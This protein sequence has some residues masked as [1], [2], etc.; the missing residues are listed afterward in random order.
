MPLFKKGEHDL[1]KLSCFQY[2]NRSKEFCPLCNSDNDPNGTEIKRWHDAVEGSEG[3][4]KL[5]AQN[6]PIPSIEGDGTPISKEISNSQ[7]S[8]WGD[9]SGFEYD[10]PTYNVIGPNG[11]LERVYDISPYAIQHTPLKQLDNDWNAWIEKIQPD[12]RFARVSDTNAECVLFPNVNNPWMFTDYV[13][14]GTGKTGYIQ[15]DNEGKISYG[16][17]ESKYVMIEPPLYDQKTFQLLNYDVKVDKYKTA[18]D[19]KYK[20]EFGITDGTNGVFHQFRKLTNWDEWRGNT[21]EE[22]KKLSLLNEFPVNNAGVKL[23]K[24]NVNVQ[25]VKWG[26]HGNIPPHTLNMTAPEDYLDPTKATLKTRAVVTAHIGSPLYASNYGVIHYVGSPFYKIYIKE[27]PF[28]EHKINL[29]IDGNSESVTDYYIYDQNAGKGGVEQP[30]PETIPPRYANKD[31]I[32]CEQYSSTGGKNEGDYIHGGCGL[33]QGKNGILKCLRMDELK[34]NPFEF[35]KQS[36]LF[37]T[38]ACTTF[39]NTSHACPHYVASRQYPLIATYQ[40]TATNSRDIYFDSAKIKQ[41]NSYG[42]GGTLAALLGRG[43]QNF[44]SV[45]G[46]VLWDDDNVTVNYEIEYRP[47]YATLQQPQK[48]K[49]IRNGNSEGLQILPNTG[50][51]AIDTTENAKVFGNDDDNQYGDIST[52]SFHRFSSSVLHCATQANCNGVCGLTHQQ[53]FDPAV[54]AGGDSECRYYKQSGNSEARGLSGCPHTGVPKRAVEFSETMMA[55]KNILEPIKN[56]LLEYSIQGLFEIYTPANALYRNLWALTKKGSILQNTYYFENEGEIASGLYSIAVYLKEYSPETYGG[57]AIKHKQESSS[58]DESSSSEDN[59]SSSSEEGE[60]YEPQELADASEYTLLFCKFLAAKSNDANTVQGI[61][62]KRVPDD[63]GGISKVEEMFDYEVH[64]YFALHTFFFYEPLYDDGSKVTKN[65]E[66]HVDEDGL[67]FCKLDEDFVKPV[68]NCVMVDNEKKFIGGY[69]P[70]YKDYSQRGEEFMIEVESD[71][72]R[73]GHAMGDLT[74]DSEYSGVA[75][76]VNKEGYWI[77]ES[78]QYI[79][80]EREIGVDKPIVDEQSRKDPTGGGVTCISIKKSNSSIDNETGKKLQPKTT[81][82]AVFSNDSYAFIEYCREKIET[83]NKY[84]EPVMEQRGPRLVDPNDDEGKTYLAPFSIKDMD[85]LPTMRKALYCPVCDYYIA[86]KYATEKNNTCPWCGAPFTI[87][88]GDKGNKGP[89]GKIPFDNNASVM[90]KF[91]KL[92]AIGQVQVW[93][94]PGTCVRKDAYFW[95]NQTPVSNA[96]KRQIYHRL[97][98]SNKDKNGNS[99][100]GYAMDKMSKESELTLGLPEGLGYFKK[101]PGDW[102]INANARYHNS[103]IS[104][105]ND[106]NYDATKYGAYNDL[107]PDNYMPHWDKTDE[108]IIAPYSQN[109]NDALKMASYDQIRILRNAIEPIMAY[110]AN[111]TTVSDGATGYKCSY[112]QPYQN[113]YMTFRASYDNRKTADQQTTYYGKKCIVEP[114]VLAATDCGKDAYQEFYSGDLQYGNVRKYYPPGYTWWFLKQCLGGRCTDRTQGQYHM[115][116]GSGWAFNCVWPTGKR[117]IAKCAMFIHGILPLDKEIVAAYILLSPGG[118]EPSENPIGRSW[119]RGG[120][121]MYHHYHAHVKEHFNKGNDQHLHGTAGFPIDTYFDDE[122]N[123][124][125]NRKPG[126]VIYYSNDVNF[127][128]FSDY[129]MWGSNSQ[130]PDYQSIYENKFFDT[131]TSLPAMLD[132]GFYKN[133]G[134]IKEDITIDG[135]V[136]GKG[137]NYIVETTDEDGNPLLTPNPSLTGMAFQ[138]TTIEEEIAKKKYNY[139]LVDDNNDIIKPYSEKMMWKTTSEETLEKVIDKYTSEMTLSVSDGT[140]KGTTSYTFTQINSDLYSDII[141]NNAQGITGYFNMSWANSTGSIYGDGY[142][143]LKKGGANAWDYPI[144]FQASNTVTGNYSGSNSEGQIGTVTRC[145]DCTDIIQKLYN[146][147]IDRHFIARGGNTYEEVKNMEI[148]KISTIGVTADSDCQAAQTI[149][150]ENGLWVLSD[151]SSYPK[152]EGTLLP[153]ISADGDKYELAEKKTILYCQVLFPIEI[154]EGNS[155]YKIKENDEEVEK[156]YGAKKFTNMTELISAVKSIFTN[157][158]VERISNSEYTISSEEALSILSDTKY[159]YASLGIPTGNFT[160]QQSRV[161]EVSSFAE[162]FSP[163]KLFDGSYGKWKINTFDSTEQYFIIDLARAPLLKEQ[164]N[165]RYRGAETDYS[166]CKCPDVNCTANK[167]TVAVAANMKGINWNS[168]SPYCFCG[169]DL[170]KDGAQTSPGDGIMTYTY[171]PPFEENPFIEKIE[172]TSTENNGISIAVKNSKHSEWRTL[173]DKIPEGSEANYSFDNKIDNRVR[174][175]YVRIGVKTI[176]KLVLHEYEIVEFD[177]FNIKI[178]GDFSGFGGHTFRGHT[179]GFDSDAT[180]SITREVS[181]A[182]GNIENETVN[183]TI[184]EY[185]I[186]SMRINETKTEATLSTNICFLSEDGKIY[187]LNEPSKVKINAPK[188]TGQVDLC[189]VLGFHYISQRTEEPGIKYLTITDIEDEMVIGINTKTSKYL[190]PEY[191][192]KIYSVQAN[193]LGTS[194]IVLTPSN[195]KDNLLWETENVQVT[196][197]QN[198]LFDI[199]KIKGGNYY[200]D[201]VHNSII[202]PTKCVL[203]KEITIQGVKKTGELNWNEFEA[204]LAYSSYPTSHI[205]SQIVIRYFSGNGKELTMEAVAGGNGPSYQLEKDSIRFIAT[206]SGME[207]CG[208]TGII[209]DVNG[210]VINNQ[211][212]E[213]TVF[214]TEPC[215]LDMRAMSY[216]MKISNLSKKHSGTFFAGTFMG[217]EIS[218]YGIENDDKFIDLFGKNNERLHGTCSTTVVFTGAPNRIIS[219][220]IDVYA[221]ATTD[222]EVDVGGGQ[223]VKYS[224]RTGGLRQ[225]C[226]IVKVSV[227]K[228]AGGLDT[229]TF[230]LPSL[231]I[232]AKE[233]NP[234]VT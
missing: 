87:I 112:S 105:S 231:L 7:Y 144:I 153:E 222:T 126:T 69:H 50:K 90:K 66:N 172:V 68:T 5:N 20:D 220:N 215:T 81:N 56:V 155:Y 4:L 159:I 25:C 11:I 60:E 189:E 209:P 205:P 14:K 110:S 180:L 190:L 28:T 47:E 27:T 37:N 227:D 61:K 170:I 106:A 214:N 152:L 191:P 142:K 206:K 17:I 201:A 72:D 129:R 9:C 166:N 78:G 95:K 122:G 57:M 1:R 70:Q 13:F 188:Y 225:G 137:Y 128:D 101:I 62:I 30:T 31:E 211:K 196:D 38:T 16:V 3:V 136:R 118:P 111:F 102:K 119:N 148:P 165:Y 203:Q 157:C 184:S 168:N 33:C 171:Y 210:K 183:E 213:W 230:Q 232:Y 71:R 185:K 162:G 223:K 178:K 99:A 117:T 132:I 234:V 53:G 73:E 147:R 21:K 202:L 138:N 40:K 24:A 96:L 59:N 29:N 208:T 192:S 181:D 163:D 79:M 141:P 116:G 12:Y 207:D 169:H 39:N 186:I 51:Y 123:Y 8:C 182:D 145:I 46:D 226:F 173:Y 2:C 204:N 97:G 197:P 194:G 84:N 35:K 10:V 100:G 52:L 23:Y 19:G 107:V 135:T 63:N 103:K 45:R 139:C 77:D 149:F 54:R 114:I 229:Q 198:H 219:G 151:S 113:D 108:G 75:Q 228:A 174:A 83:L 65:F 74:N 44:G 124:V 76:T 233:K 88:S 15:Q 55:A 41:L 80:D 93:G 131:M 187:L 26:E 92:Y 64:Y 82:G 32:C 130:K 58:S 133:V 177:G 89:W 22:N 109:A 218:Q 134:T 6:K 154:L 221:K 104:W 224:E 146:D 167:R 115:D 125:D 160:P 86:I 98:N 94:P 212:I 216:S 161:T 49:E 156:K 36:E 195:S 18:F 158:T 176:K 43:I 164:R 120:P 140:K 193:S 34:E 199:V 175:R 179:G 121:V 217:N 67:W 150:K 200:F 85:M 91:F 127:Q 48:S 42:P 143:V